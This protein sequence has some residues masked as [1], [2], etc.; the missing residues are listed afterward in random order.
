VRNFEINKEAQFDSGEEVEFE[1][2]ENEKIF[3]GKLHKSVLYL[4]LSY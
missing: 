4:H 3:P 1:R 2:G